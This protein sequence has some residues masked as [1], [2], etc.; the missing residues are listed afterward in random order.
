MACIL[1]VEVQVKTAGTSRRAGLVIGAS[2]NSTAG[3]MVSYV[4]PGNDNLYVERGG[5][6]VKLTAPA[7]I[8]VDTWYKIRLVAFGSSCSAWLD[9]TLM[10]TASDARDLANGIYVG[11]YSYQAVTWFRNFKGWILTG[12]PA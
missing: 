2:T 9:G 8:D 7:T 12:L 4:D 5:S 1:E 10:G 11:L 6:T 3:A